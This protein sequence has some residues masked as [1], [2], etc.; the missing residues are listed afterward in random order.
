M[1]INNYIGLPFKDRGRDNTGV[2]CWGLVQMVYK[3]QL[4]VVLPGFDT[5][6]AYDAKSVKRAIVDTCKADEWTNHKTPSDFDVVV[7]TSIKKAGGVV[8][9]LETHVGLVC[10]NATRLL[11]VEEGINVTCVPLD[12]MQVRSRITRFMR[13]N[14][15]NKCNS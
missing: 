1:W 3:D 11:H 10:Y 12:A 8:R 4:G 2:D 5:I 7:M 13:H 9:K 14:L 6:G 15:V